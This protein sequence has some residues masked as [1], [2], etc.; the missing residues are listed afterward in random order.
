VIHTSLY[1]QTQAL[2]NLDKLH[3]YNLS[4]PSLRLK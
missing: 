3:L 4:F 2:R 1:F